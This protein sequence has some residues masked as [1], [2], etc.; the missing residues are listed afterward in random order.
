M[1]HFLFSLPKHQAQHLPLINIIV[2]PTAG[3][4]HKRPSVNADPK[5]TLY[6]SQLLLLSLQVVSDS[7]ET[8]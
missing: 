3:G 4:G 5:V 8:V 7:F 2:V 1:H 6:K